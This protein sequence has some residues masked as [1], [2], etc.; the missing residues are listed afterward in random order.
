M[1]VFA[2]ETGKHFLSPELYQVPVAYFHQPPVVV[3][4][5][6]QVPFRI[7]TNKP[8]PDLLTSFMSKLHNYSKK[9]KKVSN[10]YITVTD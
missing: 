10:N 5:S 6:K 2:D 4:E 8:I 7:V 9:K 1:Q 3:H